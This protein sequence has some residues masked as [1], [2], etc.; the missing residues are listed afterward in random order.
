M[1]TNKLKFKNENRFIKNYEL[2]D[3]VRQFFD[4][5]IKVLKNP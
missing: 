3:Q 2:I 5:F 1:K 4:N